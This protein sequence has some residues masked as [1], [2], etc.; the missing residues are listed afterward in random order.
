MKTSKL[1]LLLSVTVFLGMAGLSPVAG[2]TVGDP[3]G[4]ARA[5]HARMV[6]DEGEWMRGEAEVVGAG[7]SD[8]AMAS[9]EEVTSE[10]VRVARGECA[11]A[12]VTGEMT[13]GEAEGLVKEGKG[14]VVVTGV[15]LSSGAGVMEGR[16]TSGAEVTKVG[17]WG[18]EVAMVEGWRRAGKAA[19]AVMRDEEGRRLVTGDS[20][21]VYYRLGYRYV[22]TAFRGNGERLRAFTAL[23]REAMEA[24]K[25]ERVVIRSFAS[26][27]GT[28]RANE[29]LSRLRADSLASWLTR[30]GGIEAGMVEKRAG[31]IGWGLLRE[32]VAASSMKWRTEVLEVL[33][34]VPE[35]IRDEAGRIV[36]GRKKRLMEVAGGEAYRY[37]YKEVFP[38]LR[39][40]ISVTLYYKPVEALAPV[41][42]EKVEEV[43][44]PQPEPEPEPAVE[45]APVPVEPAAEEEEPVFRPLLAVKTNLLYWAGV[46]PDFRSYTFVPNLE[47]EVFLGKAWSVAGS[48]NYNERRYG[49]ED[50]NYFGVSTWSV[51]GRRWFKADGRFRWLHGGVYVEWGD[52]DVQN[53][54]VTMDG[55]TG[56]TWGVGLSLGAAIPFTDRWGLEVGLRGG[57]REAADNGYTWEA[58]DYF[59]DAES[60]EHDWG[61]TGIKASLYYRFGKKQ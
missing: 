41:A 42:E 9:G 30:E 31:G 44:T 47:V 56:T 33:D 13:G 25:L 1:K 35:W 55:H 4:V 43:V 46:M 53:S 58:P 6:M 11:G 54:R 37:L 59:K 61:V 5:G 10:G 38:D 39:A 8:E 50:R 12:P 23:T 2:G 34:N 57:F 3:G 52:Y 48:V 49:D 16:G 17:Q 51:E 45:P 18:E 32:M 14:G 29:R 21:L 24:G 22:D 20:T 7:L 36:D 19:E 26:P 60:V 27:D 40:C 28:S 15:G